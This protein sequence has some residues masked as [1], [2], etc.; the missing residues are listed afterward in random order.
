VWVERLNLQE[1]VVKLV[2]TADVLQPGGESLRLGVLFLRLDDHAVDPF[3]R[4]VAVS[5]TV[6]PDGRR[7]LHLA[8]VADPLV[9]F[10]AAEC[11]PG[12]VAV[13]IGGPAVLQVMVVVGGQVRVDP[14]F[15]KNRR[16]G[17]V[18]RFQRPPA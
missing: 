18:E 2:V 1:P 6:A 10:L 16:H 12:A 5:C 15:A 7:M 17:V 11:F 14:V 4:R 9:A 13:V 3:L 8:G